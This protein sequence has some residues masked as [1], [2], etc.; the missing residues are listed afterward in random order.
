LAKAVEQNDIARMKLLA[1]MR[2]TPLSLYNDAKRVD[3]D[4][5]ANCDLFTQSKLKQVQQPDIT[6]DPT[7]M[8]DA[9]KKVRDLGLHQ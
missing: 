2:P 3:D 1:Y 7:M 9:V 6:V 4:V 5:V 8:Y